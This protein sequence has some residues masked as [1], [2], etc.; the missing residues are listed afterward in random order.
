MGDD[1]AILTSLDSDPDAFGELYRRHVDALLAYVRQRNPALAADVCA[2]TF[3]TALDGAHRFD[4]SRGPAADWLYGIADRLLAQA[5]DRH[6]VDDRARRRLGMA[7]L[8]PGDGFADALEEE[9]VAAARFR[10]ARG[11]PRVALPRVPRVR[12]LPRPRLKAVAALAVVALAVVAAIALLRGGEDGV[13][14]ESIPPPPPNAVFSLLA[15]Q[16][17]VRCPQPARASLATRGEFQGIAMLART[18]RPPDLLPFSPRRLPIGTYDP[19]TTRLAPS[20]LTSGL[21]VVPTTQVADFGGCKG[22]DGPGVCLVAAEERSFRCFTTNDV[23]AGRAVARTRN[24]VLVGIAPDG[25]GRVTLSAAG[26][27]AGADVL[28]SFFEVQLDAIRGTP[29][30]VAMQ[31]ADGCMRVV[32]PDLRRRVALLR[33]PAQPTLVLPAAAL[34][35]VRAWAGTID[36]VVDD[37][38]RFWGSRDGVDYWVVPVVPSGQEACAP[39][40][41]VCVVAIPEESFADGSCVLG[42]IPEDEQWRLA[43]LVPGHAVIYGVVPDGVTAVRVTIDGVSGDVEA[44]D[45]VVGGVLPFPF[46]DEAETRVEL[47]R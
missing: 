22:D 31:G 11:R 6:V 45:N 38:A 8:E 44:R 29:I 41:E 2:E 21:H 40:T 34:G 32:A 18:Q 35:V 4:P 47:L 7:A 30:E 17:L 20:R 23:S 27:S 36:A 43:P 9:L 33:V 25:V 28:Q 46:R 24:G 39:A 15:M 12:R 37:G 19:R 26:H 16:P 3:A 42:D 13:A 14:G 10:A 5:G 1:E